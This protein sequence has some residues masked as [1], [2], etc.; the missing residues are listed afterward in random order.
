MQHDQ[1]STPV[2][3]SVVVQEFTNS[4]LD[5]N[6]P[7]L[8]PVES[9]GTIIANT[10]PGCWGPMITPRLRGGHEVTTP[11]FIEGAEV[12]DGVAIRIREI[13]ITSIATASGHDS[14]PEGFCLGDP[15]VAARCPTCDTVWPETHIEGIGQDAVRCDV[16]N[17]P[18]KPFEIVHGYTVTFDDTRTVGLT[19]PS[20][21]AS[22]FAQRADHY[23]ALP[24]GSKQHSILNYA[25][26]DMP[27]TLIR[28]RPF[29]GQLGTCP[30]MPMPDSHNAGDF[31]AFLVGAPHEYA[32]TPEQLAE[33]KTDGHMDIDAVRAG[34]ILIAPVKVRG[35]GVYMGDMHAGQGDG[36]IAGHTMDVAGSVTLQVEVVKHYPLDG[37]VLFPLLEDLPPLAKPFSASEKA[38]GQRLAEK[39]GVSHIEP[40]APISVVG[41]AANLN[42]A[43]ENGLERAAKLLKVSVA[44]I[45]NRATV[46]GAI[47]IGRA[48]GVIQVTFLAPLAKLDEVG[49]GDYAREQYDL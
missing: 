33:H 11:V 9:G 13:T 49:L 17:N 42:D 37:P 43:I 40:L 21:V 7:M 26:S 27:G 34:A 16:C 46:N 22:T 6:A 44:E 15:Y 5:P 32:I 41:T 29:M 19:V 12:G 45:R 23:S 25:P 24:D 31:G 48:P 20:D 3:R 2:R 28:T 38:K 18:V 39:W 8:G 36:E 4:V 1:S 47:E 10:A 35:A 30:S 14:S